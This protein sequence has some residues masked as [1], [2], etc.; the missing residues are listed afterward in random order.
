[1]SEHTPG[2]W[3]WGSGWRLVGSRYDVSKRENK[4]LTLGLYGADGVQIIPIRV[5]HYQPEWD[6]DEDL[7]QPNDADRALIEA[8]PDLLLACKSAVGAFKH[9]GQLVMAQQME[10]VIAK[11]E[12]K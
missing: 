8:A 6:P 4:Y 7:Q 12:G 9:S 1:M 3:S 10:K 2:P 11:A 5:D